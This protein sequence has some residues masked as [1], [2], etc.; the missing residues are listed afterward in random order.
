MVRRPTGRLRIDP[1]KP[2]LA[3]V[4]FVD[5]DVNDSNRIVVVNPVVQALGKQRVLLSVRPFNKALHEMLPQNHAGIIRCE[6]LC[7]AAFSHSH[8]QKRPLAVSRSMSG[9]PAIADIAQT[10]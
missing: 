10:S 5:K 8:G 6:S 2:K 3:E 1:L 9:P 7:T 4:E